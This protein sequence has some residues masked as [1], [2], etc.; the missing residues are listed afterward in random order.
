MAE[1]GWN[2]WSVKKH[3]CALFFVYLISLFNAFFVKMMLLL[4][5]FSNGCS[6]WKILQMRMAKRNSSAAFNQNFILRLSSFVFFQSSSNPPKCSYR[7]IPSNFW[8]NIQFVHLAI[9]PPKKTIYWFI[10]S[11]RKQC[12]SH[13]L[14]VIKIISTLTTIYILPGN[15]LRSI[16]NDVRH[17]YT[18]SFVSVVVKSCKQSPNSLN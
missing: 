6:R 9:L 16:S 10:W 1:G 7:W 4:S 11:E 13:I 18:M 17:V 12:P 2:S 3:K 15:F 5:K 14:H 8:L